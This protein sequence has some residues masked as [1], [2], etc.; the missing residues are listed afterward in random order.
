MSTRRRTKS[1]VSRHSTRHPVAS[2]VSPFEPLESR[3]MFAA[4]STLQP[5]EPAFEINP[6]I[7]IS[8]GGFSSFSVTD[9]SYDGTSATAF[10]GGALRVSFNGT[11]AAASNVTVQPC[12]AV[13]SSPPSAPT[14]PPRSATG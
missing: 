11:F 9:A 4:I 5:I 13:R 1:I 12:R 10:H 3:R 6:N 7:V 2:P 14:P 8:N